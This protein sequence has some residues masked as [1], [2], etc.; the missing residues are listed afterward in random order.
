MMTQAT[1]I[2]ISNSTTAD[3]TMAIMI[4]VLGLPSSDIWIRSIELQVADGH[5][6]VTYVL[7]LKHKTFCTEV[8]RHWCGTSFV[9]DQKYTSIQ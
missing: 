8:K 7:L 6:S 3:T 1:T 5:Y 2:T 9:W 4:L